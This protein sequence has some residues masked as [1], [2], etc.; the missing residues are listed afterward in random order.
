M[1]DNNEQSQTITKR[2]EPGTHILI[3]S[4]CL[5]IEMCRHKPEY[6]SNPI[7]VPEGYELFSFDMEQMESNKVATC[8]FINRVPVE[9]TGEYST[10]YETY[11]FKY[12][13]VVI[14][15]LNLN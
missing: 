15:S 13:G 14:K 1:A 5:G 9:A 3:N 4:F 2:F 11:L 6:K 8:V 7:E 10:L 12:P